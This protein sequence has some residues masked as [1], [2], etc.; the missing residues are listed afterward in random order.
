MD[1]QQK[2]IDEAKI[3][4]S[5]KTD[6]TGKPDIGHLQKSFICLNGK[7]LNTCP[8]EKGKDSPALTTFIHHCT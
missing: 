3:R 6:T 8:L 2:K 4:F 5:K 7:R 1:K